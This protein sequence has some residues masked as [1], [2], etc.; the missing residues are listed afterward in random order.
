MNEVVSDVIVPIGALLGIPG[1]ILGILNSWRLFVSDRVR[2]KVTPERALL[3]SDRSIEADYLSIEVINLSKF[4][5]TIINVGLKLSGNRTALFL[6]D[7]SIEPQ[8]RLPI[9]L[10]SRASYS[11]TFRDCK[12]DIPWNEVIC[13][14][15][16]TACGVTAKGT[17]KFLKEVIRNGWK[18]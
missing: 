17:S 9:R 10:E 13:V 15:A 5:V 7:D 2:L 8:G 14:Y 16:K 11:K 4:P 1:A 3:L 12:K 6:K 18:E